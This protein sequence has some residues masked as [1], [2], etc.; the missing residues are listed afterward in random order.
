MFLAKDMMQHKPYSSETASRIDEEVKQILF[1]SYERAKK[2]L[3]ENHH[4]LENLAKL[5]IEKETVDGQE[6]RKIYDILEVA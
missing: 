4:A 3:K 5:L 6:V 2:I 1:T